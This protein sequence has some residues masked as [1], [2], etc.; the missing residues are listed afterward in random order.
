MRCS[1]PAAA[2]LESEVLPAYLPK[3]RWFAAKDAA[4]RARAHRRM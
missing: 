2:M 4:D 1:R 3:R